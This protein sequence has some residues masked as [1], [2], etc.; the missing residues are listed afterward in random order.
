MNF[1]IQIL[2]FFS[3]NQI[4]LLSVEKT[5]K[6]NE[7]PMIKFDQLLESPNVTP[8]KIYSS[9]RKK[10][11]TQLSPKTEKL[12]SIPLTY[13]SERDEKYNLKESI[14]SLL[15][16]LTV[17]MR[18]QQ[19]HS[20]LNHLYLILQ[21]YTEIE[22]EEEMLKELESLK[23]SYFNLLKIKKEKNF[24]EILQ[25]EILYKKKWN[26]FLQHNQDKFSQSICFIDKDG[27]FI[28]DRWIL[29]METKIEEIP[30]SKKS[31]FEEL[32][33]E[34]NS[35][36]TIF[37]E[38]KLKFEMIK[39][40]D[41]PSNE[42]IWD[43]ERNLNFLEFR[44]YFYKYCV[45]TSKFNRIKTLYELLPSIIEVSNDLDIFET[46][47]FVEGGNRS[48]KGTFLSD[49]EHS[50]GKFMK[51]I[52]SLNI[53]FYKDLIYSQEIK[54]D[55]I[56]EIF[57]KS[58]KFYNILKE[59]YPKIYENF[60]ENQELSLKDQLQIRLKFIDKCCIE[61]N[62]TNSLLDLYVSLNNAKFSISTLNEKIQS[63]LTVNST[64]PF[65]NFF[66][67]RQTSS[68]NNITPPNS[69][70]RK[71][72]ED[73]RIPPFIYLDQVWKEKIELTNEL[74]NPL[75]P[76]EFSLVISVNSIYKHLKDCYNA[77]LIYLSFEMMKKKTNENMD[78]FLTQ[79]KMFE[80]ILLNVQKYL[81]KQN[82]KHLTEM[83]KIF[84]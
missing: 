26:E 59:S 20:H 55:Q 11:E 39:E 52:H 25:S 66:S 17:V 44:F 29:K 35:S 5:H 56:K 36:F 58:L 12:L 74:V 18:N 30:N 83:K 57:G 34:K 81:P 31:C 49:V 64:S 3:S 37:I 54:E 41:S 53:Q 78:D 23:D 43:M 14:T 47:N 82:E 50:F 45:N 79:L 28:K 22:E 38:N 67:P 2:Y 21:K 42:E 65:W 62:L 68:F 69:K 13:N 40:N 75:N 70:R 73:I 27:S 24:Q 32:N 19:Y 61:L 72:S 8:K 4:S 6:M 16:N 1:K 71:S 33:L 84:E 51:D 9:P 76:L 48:L 15:R 46:V 60:I 7:V 63:N 77:G 80:S 10:T